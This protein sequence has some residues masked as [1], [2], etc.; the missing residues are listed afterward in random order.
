LANI[1][2]SHHIAGAERLK[3]LSLIMLLVAISATCYWLFAPDEWHLLCSPEQRI[4]TP[5]QA[6]AFAKQQIVKRSRVFEET[7]FKTSDEYV[8]AVERD[9]NCCSALY[10]PRHFEGAGRG[11]SV[12]IF[13]LHLQ[14]K[15]EHAVEFNECGDISY[16]GGVSYLK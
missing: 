1:F 7:D 14:N 9:P 10:G 11:W 3:K 8:A 13:A 16:N 12:T 2:E 4:R 5:E 6:I 15:Y